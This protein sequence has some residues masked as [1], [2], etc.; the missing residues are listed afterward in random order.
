MQDKTT[1]QCNLSFEASLCQGVTRVTR[2][3]R[4]LNADSVFVTWRENERFNEYKKFCQQLTQQNIFVVPH[5]VARNILDHDQLNSLL[6]LFQRELRINSIFILAGDIKLPRGPYTDAYDLLCSVDFK[7]YGIDK[8]Y[9]PAYPQG[10]PSIPDVKLEQSFLEKIT[11][12]KNNNLCVEVVT[13]PTLDFEDT[14]LWMNKIALPN[15]LTTRI[16]IPVFGEKG[17]HNFAKILGQDKQIV[18]KRNLTLEKRL[19]ALEKFLLNDDYFFRH[20]NL[21]LI[22]FQDLDCLENS[23]NTVNNF[24]RTRL[25]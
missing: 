13:Q 7:A 14:F 11:F 22:S 17:L 2:L 1:F 16:S 23:K 3:A 9:I 12:V 15:K 5:L 25:S 18:T 8:I 24:I 21:H 6:R 20:C 4:E 19:S 10:H